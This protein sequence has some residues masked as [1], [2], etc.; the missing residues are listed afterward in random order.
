V[1]RLSGEALQNRFAGEEPGACGPPSQDYFG[2][3]LLRVWP[4][5]DYGQGQIVVIEKEEREFA[6]SP[7]HP[8]FC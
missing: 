4:E 7:L 8:L 5:K 2:G 3:V 6:G 1:G